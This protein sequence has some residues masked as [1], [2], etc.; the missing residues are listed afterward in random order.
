[1]EKLTLEHIS[2]KEI[3]LSNGMIAYVDTEDYDY[4]S[5]FNWQA[6]KSNHTYY[7]SRKNGKGRVMMHRQLMNTP[8]GKVCDHKDRNGLNNTKLNL[9]NCTHAENC[10]NNTIGNNFTSKYHGVFKIHDN[11]FRSYIN[12][13]GKRTYIG[14]FKT[15]ELAAMAYNKKAL[16]LHGE[17]ATINTF[18]TNPYE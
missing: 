16:E 12:V 3:K 8:K 5:S 13:Y 7:A 9:R 6:Q 4:I 17:F 15:E 2:P 10:R 11:R 14:Y 18:E 1:M